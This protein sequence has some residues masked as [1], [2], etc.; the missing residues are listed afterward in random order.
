[1]ANHKDETNYYVDPASFGNGVQRIY[2]LAKVQSNYYDEHK[3][4]AAT[5]AK[6]AEL[7]RLLVESAELLSE[8]VVG[9]K[10]T[11]VSSFTTDQKLDHIC[12]MLEDLPSK[13]NTTSVAVPVSPKPKKKELSS[14]EIMSLYYSKTNKI[15]Q[16]CL[17]SP[18]V[19]IQ[20]FGKMFRDWFQIRFHETAGTNFFF[21]TSSIPKWVVDFIGYYGYCMGHN[22]CDQFEKDFYY[23]CANLTE[24][25][26]WEVSH[27]QLPPQ[28][29]NNEIED[30][31]RHCNPGSLLI[32]YLIR[33][34]LY[35]EDFFPVNSEVIEVFCH[36]HGTYFRNYTVEQLIQ[37]LDLHEVA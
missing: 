17:T 37:A 25:P 35:T 15:Y 21:K 3:A 26:D 28:V 13:L 12:K 8:H 22:M 33:P 18:Y 24:H 7:C 16:T 31:Q 10:L 2:R 5:K 9:N 6:Y 14:K 20:K 32:E 19:E 11:D 4:N 29:M 30:V 27:C 36:R 23:W 34:L 1:M